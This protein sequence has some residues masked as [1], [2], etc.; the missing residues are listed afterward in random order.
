VWNGQRVSLRAGLDSV[1]RFSINP[2]VGLPQAA[3]GQW[4]DHETLLLHLDL[5]GAINDYQFK[6]RFSED[7]RSLKVSLSE[8]TGLNDEQFEG[9]L[10][11]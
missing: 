11:R 4:L 7:G 9:V 1:E 8:R 5:V 2:L 10:S 3:K 6:L